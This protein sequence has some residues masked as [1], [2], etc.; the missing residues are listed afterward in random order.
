MSIIT[1]QFETF[2]PKLACNDLHYVHVRLHLHDLVFF[3]VPTYENDVNVTSHP[4]F[5]L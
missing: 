2:H 5:K 4:D 1:H 3:P